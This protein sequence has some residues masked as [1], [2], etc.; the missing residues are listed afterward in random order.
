MCPQESYLA[1]VHIDSKGIVDGLR[2]AERRREGALAQ[3]RRTPDVWIWEELRRVRQEVK[4]V[5]VEHV[6]PHRSKKEK[7][8]MSQTSWQKTEQ[9]MAQIRASTVQQEKRGGLCGVARR[10]QFSLSGEGMGRL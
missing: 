6:N 8:Q 9:W 2:T 1:M 5:E 7:Q 10:S 3:G 4:L